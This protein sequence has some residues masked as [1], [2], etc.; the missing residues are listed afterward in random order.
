MMPMVQQ[1]ATPGLNLQPINLAQYYGGILGWVF[2]MIIKK[3]KLVVS[4]DF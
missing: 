4:K 2:S 3:K 1:Q